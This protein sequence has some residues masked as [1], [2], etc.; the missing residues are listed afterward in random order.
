[1]TARS[2]TADSML[3]VAALLVA[4]R[5]AACRF[6]PVNVN[7][8]VFPGWHVRGCSELIVVCAG[9]VT[10]DNAAAMQKKQAMNRASMIGS[11]VAGVLHR[12]TPSRRRRLGIDQAG[13]YAW[14][15]NGVRRML[16]G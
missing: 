15:L 10:A 12:F 7:F 8:V 16:A 2:A 14:S 9:N 11:L 5:N 3:T 1:M 13:A 6:L 4:I